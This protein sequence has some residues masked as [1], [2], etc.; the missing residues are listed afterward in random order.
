MAA[1]GAEPPAQKPTL[2]ANE[3]GPQI[4]VLATVVII[5]IFIIVVA[6]MYG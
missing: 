2:K 5:A 3:R 1:Q 4:A 6:A